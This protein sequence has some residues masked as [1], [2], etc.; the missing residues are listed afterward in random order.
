LKKRRGR[1]WEGVRSECQVTQKHMHRFEETILKRDRGNDVGE[2]EPAGHHHHQ[3][4]I[5]EQQQ[6]VR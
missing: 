5:H 2:R 6:L 3:P 1:W 4:S